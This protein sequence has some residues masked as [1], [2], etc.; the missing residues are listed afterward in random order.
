ME[1][2]ARI[3]QM[4]NCDHRELIVEDKFITSKELRHNNFI[5]VNVPIL[6]INTRDPIQ[7]HNR[8][9]DLLSK[10]NKQCP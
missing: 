1:G 7:G 9:F 10:S 3:E 6:V 8:I 5:V 2:F 4:L